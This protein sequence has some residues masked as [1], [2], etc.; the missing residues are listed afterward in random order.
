MAMYLLNNLYFF[1]QFLELVIKCLCFREWSTEK[2]QYLDYRTS[3]TGGNS[4]LFISPILII[5]FNERFC[6]AETCELVEPR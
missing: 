6:V 1:F 5:T 4:F 2:Y 3:L